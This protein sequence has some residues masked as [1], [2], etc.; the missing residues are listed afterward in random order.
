MKRH[1]LFSR[2]LALLFTCS[3]IFFFSSSHACA[4]KVK[5]KIDGTVY[6][7][8]TRL[9][10][11]I[12]EDIENAQLLPIEGNH[13][14]VNVEVPRDAFVRIHDYKEWPER[15]VFVLIPDSRHISINW[16]E[17]TIEGSAKSKELQMVCQQVQQEG[18]NNF[19][20]D[21]FSDDKE[22]WAQARAQE[23]IMR[24]GMQMQQI[25]TIERVIKENNN[26]NFPAWIVYCYHS[27]LEGPFRHIIDEN[28]NHKWAKHTIIKKSGV[29]DKP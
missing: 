19:H 14:S 15:S 24:D 21:V 23:K 11:I 5:L 13:F 17:G 7:T 6:S 18:P 3:L 10:L 25:Q 12:N 22:A 1:S 8:Q 2:S 26:N 29:L 28:K 4:K 16:P 9:Y 20:I 27:L